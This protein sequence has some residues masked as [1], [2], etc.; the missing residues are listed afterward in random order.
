MVAPTIQMANSP[1]A[2][3]ELTLTAADNGAKSAELLYKLM[4]AEID[5][6]LARFYVSLNANLV[7]EDS[8]S[9]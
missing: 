1:Q 9:T 6:A 4:V 8:R 5:V 2:I 7:T 3:I